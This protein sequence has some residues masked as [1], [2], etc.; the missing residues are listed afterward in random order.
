MGAGL[1]LVAADK[2][3]DFWHA[4]DQMPCVIVHV[5][6]NEHVAGKELAVATAFLP[7]PHLDHFFG[8][9]QNVAEFSPAY[10]RARCVP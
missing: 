9:D 3:H 4:L 5:H 6:L 10:L 2:A 7:G 8:W 1:S